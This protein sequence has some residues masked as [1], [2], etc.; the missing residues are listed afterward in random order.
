MKVI[1]VQRSSP[2][3]RGVG[4]NFSTGGGVV[5]NGNFLKGCYCTD[6]CPN[7]LYRKCIKFAPKKG[8]RPPPPLPTPLTIEDDLLNNS[9]YH[10][11]G[12]G[13]GGQMFVYTCSFRER[14][15][16]FI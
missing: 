8:G 6:L 1:I 14:V 9:L 16:I 15:A 3:I 11:K 5:L 13:G 2:T 12:W 7:T 10:V 4:R